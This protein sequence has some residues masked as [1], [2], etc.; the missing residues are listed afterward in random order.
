[1]ITITL[2]EPH[3]LKKKLI[4]SL[5]IDG[6][7]LSFE[8]SKKSLFSDSDEFENMSSTASSTIPIMPTDSFEKMHSS[9][10]SNSSFST[11]GNKIIDWNL[12]YSFPKKLKTI[13]NKNNFKQ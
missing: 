3:N 11:M 8:E 6:L 4:Q 7:P 10:S 1:L 12:K 2:A 9:D 5:L 13:C